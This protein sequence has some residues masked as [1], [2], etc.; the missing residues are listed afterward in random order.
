MLGVRRATVNEAAR[1]LQERGLITYS[2]G[3]MTILDRE[4]LEG[5]SCECY[6]RVNDEFDRLFPR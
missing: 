1:N 3:R 5:V 6:R 4:A 2:R